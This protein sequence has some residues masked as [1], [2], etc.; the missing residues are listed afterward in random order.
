MIFVRLITAALLALTAVPALA[1]LGPVPAGGQSIVPSGATVSRTLASKLG[2]RLTLLD[3]GAACNGSTDD[4]A[5]IRAAAASGR[6]IDIPGG[7][8]CAGA[9]IA[10]SLPFGTFAG[11]GQVQDSSGNLRGPQSSGV[12]SNPNPASWNSTTNVNDPCVA[13]LTCWAKF[14]YSHALAAEEWFI[15]DSAGGHTLGQPQHG[16]EYMPGAYP[17]TAIFNNRSGWNQSLTSND[18]RTAAV[19][20]RII[21]QQGGAGD[22]MLNEA[23]ILCAGV[24]QTG[25]TDWL[26]VPGCAWEAG[27]I[28]ALSPSQ[29]LQHSEWH[30]NDNANDVSA[31]GRVFGYNRTATTATLNN[32]WVNELISCNQTNLAAPLGCDAGYVVQGKWRIGLDFTEIASQIVAPIAMQANQKI[33]LNGSYVDGEGNPATTN[34]GNDWI[35]DDGSNVVVAQNGA[36]VLRASNP[37]AGVNHWHIQGNATGG[38]LY[39]SAEGSDSSIPIVFSD[40]GGGGVISVSNGLVSLDTIALA[41]SNAYAQMGPTGAGQA[42][43]IQVLSSVA[44]DLD[45]IASNGGTV[46]ASGKFRVDMHTPASSSEPCVGGQITFDAN[47]QYDCVATNTWKRIALSSW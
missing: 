45:L 35:T 28:S 20:N 30:F 38:D 40:K 27:D 31:I 43:I 37:A 13:S 42:Y 23:E 9:S 14:D 1:Q 39:L 4:S 25:T 18:G 44:T 6:R 11:P 47:Y 29:Y 10:S 34:L 7:L 24:A 8:V 36:T 12:T 17:H 5:A 26:A 2:D 33:T 22:M 3:F 32:R 46:H 15:A 21:G 41:G 19:Y 16:Y